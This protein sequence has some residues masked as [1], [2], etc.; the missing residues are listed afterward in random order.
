VSWVGRG[1]G[2]AILVVVAGLLTPAGALGQGATFPKWSLPTVV[3]RVAPTIQGLPMTAVRRHRGTRMGLHRSV[4]RSIRLGG[5][6]PT[7]AGRM[8]GR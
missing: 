5:P 3:D 4:R 7:A 2:L 8:A 1:A 6:I